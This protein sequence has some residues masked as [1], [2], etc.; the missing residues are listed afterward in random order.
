LNKEGSLRKRTVRVKKEQ[1]NFGNFDII[2]DKPFSNF[3]SGNSA[4]R[5]N[6]NQ[7]N[8]TKMLQ[9]SNS[10]PFLMDS[11]PDTVVMTTQF[12]LKS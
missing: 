7:I 11:L 6:E 4:F 1:D 3:G 10:V 9:A 8:P 2:A 5:T 12:E